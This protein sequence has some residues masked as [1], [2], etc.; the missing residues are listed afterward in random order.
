MDQ[1]EQLPNILKRRSWL[2]LAVLLVVSLLFRNIPL[3]V[4]ILCG[5]LVSIGGF[6]W[7]RRSLTQVL[8]E[9]TPG[10]KARYQFGYVVRLIALAFVLVVLI[11]ILK[12]DA[13]GLI[14]GLSVIVIN[15]FW[16]MIQHSLR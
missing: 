12:I 13:V 15:L 8:A 16:T 14:V 7:L 1:I 4:G 2:I 10:A 6:Y 3:T 9:P 11:A 5:G